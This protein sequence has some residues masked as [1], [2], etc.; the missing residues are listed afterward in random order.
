MSFRIGQP[1]TKQFTFLFNRIFSWYF[2]SKLGSRIKTAKDN[3]DS[4]TCFHKNKDNHHA[5]NCRAY[6]IYQG[7]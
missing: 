7:Y 1:E 4:D 2:D 3:G 6:P 5:P